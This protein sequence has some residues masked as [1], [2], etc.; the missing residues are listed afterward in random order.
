MSLLLILVTFSGPHGFEGREIRLPL[1]WGVAGSHYRNGC[2]MR[3]N[4]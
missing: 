1:V 3:E 2:G 4:C